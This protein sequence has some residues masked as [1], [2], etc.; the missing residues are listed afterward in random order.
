MNSKTVI[1]EIVMN[2]NKNYEFALL[3]IFITGQ[4]PSESISLSVLSL[5]RQ[6]HSGLPSLLF[7]FKEL[8]GHISHLQVPS[9]C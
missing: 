7:L 9:S 3:L 2:D 5:Q 4:E 1:V 8:S 6:G